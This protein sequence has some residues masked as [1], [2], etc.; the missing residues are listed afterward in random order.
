MAISKVFLWLGSI[1]LVIAAEIPVQS[2]HS[3]QEFKAIHEKS[4]SDEAEELY[5]KT[6]FEKNVAKISEHNERFEAG[7]ESYQM[8]VNHFTDKLLSEVIGGG[9]LPEGLDWAKENEEDEFD[10]I[11]I[12]EEVDW[13]TE[14]GVVTPVKDQGKC[15][16]CWAFS[17]TG[18]LEGQLKLRK[19][20]TVSLSESQL[21]DCSRY[22]LGCSGGRVSWA[23]SSIKETGIESEADYPYVAEQKECRFDASKVVAHV[24]GY[25]AVNRFFPSEKKLTQAIATVGPISVAIYA[26]DN[27]INYK[28]GVFYD[29]FCFQIRQNHAVLAVGYGHDKSTGLDFYIVKNSW[30]ASW[31]ENGYVRMVRNKWNRCGIAS[32]TGYPLV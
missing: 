4:Y 22:N 11:S 5:R 2:G 15:G 32:Q 26:N 17:T 24:Q 13:R 23:F 31:G 7:L 27:F 12:P 10:W 25:Q 8:G 19:N 1:V 6:I 28:R 21:V 30:S 20:I 3:W 18:S 29:K 14:K 9:I 16:S